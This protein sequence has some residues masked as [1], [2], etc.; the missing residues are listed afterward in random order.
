MAPFNAGIINLKPGDAACDEACAD[1]EGQL[2]AAGL[3]VLID[4]TDERAGGKFATMDLIG[5]PWQAVVG[6]RGIKNGIIEVK[7]RR[8]GEKAELSMTDAVNRIAGFE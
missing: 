3:D 2:N 4:D 5:L 7:H 8:T 6:P 1:L